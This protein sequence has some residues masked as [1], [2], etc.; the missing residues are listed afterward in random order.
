L[1]I[2]KFTSDIL[3]IGGGGAAAMAAL[4]QILDGAYVTLISKE[5]SPVSGATIMSAGG[6]CAVLSP[7][8]SPESFY[9]DIMKGGG[10]LNNPKLVK[11]LA[12][13]ST[14]AL[15][16]LEDY[17]FRLDR[18][19]LDA[20]MRGEGH[21]WARGYLDR[22]EGVGFCNGLS[23][24]LIRSGVDF[25][26]EIVAYKLLCNSGRVVGA[27][28]FNLVTGDYLVFNAKA[29]ILATGGLGAL[30]KV[31]TN[32]R[33]LTGDGYAMAWDAGAE[34]VDME[35]MQFLPLAFPYPKSREGLNI[36][37]C[38]LFG[39]EVKLYNGIG[40]RYMAKYD[41]E[42]MEFSTRDTVSRANF[43]EIK[44]G[45]GTKNGAI[46]V[47]TRDHD[48]SI[49][50]RFQSFHP[51]IYK[52]FKEIFGERVAN[53]QEPFEAIPSQHFFMGGIIIDENCAT[54]IP[55]LFAVGE[56]TGGVHGANRLAGCA[57][58]EILVFGDL[59]GE[60]AMQWVRKEDLIPP[61][62]SEIKEAIDQFER[63]FSMHQGGIRPF[64][65]K[66][67]I[68]NIMWDHFGPSRDG[69]EMKKGLAKLQDIQE[70]DLPH[71]VLGSHQTRY[72]RDKMEAVEIKLMIKTA[73][74]VAHAA[75]SRPESRGSHYRSDFP[76][77]DDNQW[78]KNIVLRKGSDGKVDI[79]FRRAVD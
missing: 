64:E 47:D 27:L 39:P 63:V 54:S 50:K 55:G 25:R 12:E 44:E 9:D 51:H 11:I 21:S 72:N 49:L 70:I 2:E 66:Q 29:V 6:I 36:G 5:N 24:A 42:R 67:A 13:G 20:V 56:V 22:R 57:L 77:S 76:L 1:R 79:S 73:I 68:K 59:V 33:P 26:P 35:M 48:P 15:F 61:I 7:D 60:K 45:R 74:L 78:L 69:E 52:M 65:L 3:I 14:R 16:K 23:R 19:G 71:L 53:W 43:T 10:Y 46:L 40:E 32:S 18:K 4:P 37:I 38:S 28:G 75:L 62:E 31:T 41:P 8:D 34:L 17:G 58:T 30:Y